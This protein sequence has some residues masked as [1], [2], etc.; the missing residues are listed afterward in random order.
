MHR[1]LIA[2]AALLAA[3]AFAYGQKP[4][5]LSVYTWSREDIF[6]GL[7]GG[8]YQQL[9]TGMTKLEEIL[10][11]SP[12]DP[13]ALAMKAAGLSALAVRDLDKGDMTG[14]DRQ[15]DEAIRL[16][17][18]AYELNAQG[19]G[20]NAVYGGTALYNYGKLPEKRRTHALQM[21]RRSYNFLYKAQEQGLDKLPLHLKGEVLAGIA[22]SEFRAGNIPQAQV[23]LKRIVETL[24]D[25]AYARR[26]QQW[27]ANPDSVTPSSRLVCQSCHD[28]GRL[29]NV[30]ATR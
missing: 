23:Y 30:L 22:E 11:Q 24:P 8:N 10:K 26:A 21:A 27:L 13:D 14:F 4:Q 6:A 5:G 2:I 18:M 25:T 1:R 12:K 29:K 3:A 9:N 17:D 20:V 16:L 19:I 15:Y 7:I 28:D